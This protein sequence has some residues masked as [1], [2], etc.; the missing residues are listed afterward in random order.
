MI[1]KV[2]NVAY[3]YQQNILRQY[4]EEDTAKH[5]YYNHGAVTTFNQE[6]IGHK[7]IEIMILRTPE[8]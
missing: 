2:K 7:G 6:E 1:E 4:P 8:P 5:G 3:I